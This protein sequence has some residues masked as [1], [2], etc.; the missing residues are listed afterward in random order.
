MRISIREDTRG[1]L[2]KQLQGLL[3][4][5]RSCLSERTA[6]TAAAAAAVA[7]RLHAGGLVSGS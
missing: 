5:A 2:L 4:Q 6:V 3:V 1:Y 7:N